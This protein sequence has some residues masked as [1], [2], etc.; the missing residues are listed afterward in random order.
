MQE[1][2]TQKEIKI[3]LKNCRQGGQSLCE[4]KQDKYKAVITSASKTKSFFYTGSIMFSFALA[5][6][7]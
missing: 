1:Y 7:K 4:N 5:T 3:L 2:C 6:T